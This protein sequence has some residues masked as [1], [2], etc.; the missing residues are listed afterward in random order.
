MGTGAS[1]SMPD[2]IDFDCFASLT[3]TENTAT[4]WDADFC[5][6]VFDCYKEENGE[7]ILKENMQ[8]LQ[9]QLSI[10]EEEFYLAAK[11]H[12]RIRG[13]ELQHLFQSL[14]VESAD[15]CVDS[16]K[17]VNLHEF[18]LVA[19]LNCK[20]AT[21]KAED[22]YKQTFDFIDCNNDGFID[23]EEM[24]TFFETL[25]GDDAEEAVD[26]MFD[27]FDFDKDGKLSL[28]EYRLSQDALICSPTGN[29]KCEG[30]SAKLNPNVRL[31]LDGT[32]K[33]CDRQ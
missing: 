12:D 7:Y 22:P 17:G 18:I 4:N 20:G 1:F 8:S 25:G 29:V 21:T 10:F 28:E 32:S 9:S 15:T 24:V 27:E 16:E 26:N 33:S 6:K 23:R 31:N 11:N 2:A 13:H 19:L 30:F 14:G 5:R 3:T